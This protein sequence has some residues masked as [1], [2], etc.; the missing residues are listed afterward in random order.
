MSS[1]RQQQVDQLR[2]Q[3]NDCV[4]DDN[5]SEAILHYT[6]AIQQ[7]KTNHLLYSNRSLAFLK[8]DQYYF[9]LEDAK[10]AI[11]LQPNWP[12]G[13]YRKGEVE[14]KVG[15]YTASLISYGQAF[16]LDPT[17]QDVKAAIERTNK[18]LT[19]IRKKNARQPWLFT[20]AGFLLG[21]FIVV[22]DQLLTKQPSINYVILQIIMVLIF[23][24]LG[25]LTFKIYKYIQDSQ[26]NSLLEP[27]V[28]LLGEMS[29]KSAGD[30]SATENDGP[31]NSKQSEVKHRRGGAAAGKQRYK[32]GKS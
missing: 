24:G 8:L 23:S 22:A 32:K 21:V 4:K 11:K 10:E 17:N 31:Q 9:A 26:K 14:F 19:H 6:H 30:T 13:F 2:Q 7:D 15:Q 18:E 25:F 1:A 5:Y 27:P 3:G 20:G 28:D 29:G 12:K 16:L